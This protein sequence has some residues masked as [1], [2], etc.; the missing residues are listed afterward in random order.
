M[1][2][3]KILAL[4]LTLAL[5]LPIFVSCGESAQNGDTAEGTSGAGLT[6]PSADGSAETE[7]PEEDPN[8]ALYTDLPAGNYSGRTFTVLTPRHTEYDFVGEV[9]GDIIS[10][11]VYKRNAAA[12]SDLNISLVTVTEPGLWDDRDGYTAKVKN[13]VLAAD[14][15]YQ[16][17]A[18]YGAYITAVAAD[19]VFAN[20]NDVTEI[21][22]EKPWW[23]SDIVYEMNVAD[24]LFYITGDLTMTSVEY[25][26]CIFFNKGLMTDTG[27]E[28]PY[29]LVREG[30]W[31]FDTMKS[32][33]ET[34]SIDAD[35]DG[36][37]TD[38]DMYGYSTDSTNF[39]SGYMAA[40][41]A[42]VTVKGDD[43]IPVLA[44]SEESFIDKFMSLYQFVCV[45]PCVFLTTEEGSMIGDDRDAAKVFKEARA[46]MLADILGNAAALREL[47]FDFGI[48]PYPKYT[49]EQADY[50]TTAWDAYNL[51]SVPRTADLDFAGTVT[52]N[53]AA[54]SFQ[55]VLPAFY[56]K[57]LLSKYA[58]DEDSAEMIGLIRGGAT[59]NFGVVN[60]PH[61]GSP[62]HIWRDLV[63]SKSDNIASKTGKN[64]K[65]VVKLLE[66]F[67][68]K[69]YLGD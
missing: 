35:G 41:D 58:R 44:I 29:T 51:Y 9:D 59:Y 28:S 52:E 39:I 27:L 37:M 68:Q 12:E 34:L 53:L 5:L 1:N 2:K 46:L 22:F 15:A 8:A 38:Q 19:G 21:N 56:D 67:I 65:S 14:D 61:I 18:G 66:K 7:A 43:G 4:L 48:I 6:T 47:D 10:E 64:E 45:D 32:Y 30:K 57:A 49:E 60:S 55:F 69:T 40:F 54:R 16:L 36:K 25:L 33:A 63:G 3:R 24:H 26:F 50:H 13:S 11:A 62:G 31:T 20:W 23:N 17:V 42:D